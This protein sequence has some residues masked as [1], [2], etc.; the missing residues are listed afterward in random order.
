MTKFSAN[1][2]LLYQE[3]PLEERFAAAA[4]DGFKAVECWAPYPLG[5]AAV[6]RR[7]A[8][9]GLAFTGLN[10]W[11]GPEG[12]WGIA[13][14]PG[15]EDAFERSIGD[16]L[17]FAEAIGSMTLHVM[18]GLV[19][20]VIAFDA[21]R[22][23]MRNLEKAVR[24]A[25]GSAVR[26][27]IEPLNGRDRPGYVLSDVEHAARI[28]DHF[29]PERLQMMFDCYHVQMQQGSVFARLERNLSRIAHVQIAGVPGRHEPDRGELD[30]K[31]LLRAIADVG[32]D[33]WIGAEYIPRAA[34][35]EGL[36]WRDHVMS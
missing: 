8:D 10:T 19:G 35:A 1:L 14:I 23:Y 7:L 29:G 16:G 15:H 33:G 25:E 12:M 27:V 32:Y 36:G 24:R 22:T 2:S 31:W 21:D 28:I 30:Y 11:P 6:S 18:G 4:A 17:E 34:T 20:S 9:E 13:A 5:A 3:L 26:L